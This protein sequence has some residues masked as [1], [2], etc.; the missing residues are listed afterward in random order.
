M[1]GWPVIYR[2]KDFSCR[3]AAHIN[4]P[5]GGMGMNG[6]IHDAVNLAEN[7]RVF[8]AVPRWKIWE[9][10]K[11]RDAVAIETVQA[12]ALRN[13]AILN[14]E[15]EAQRSAY[16]KEL[17]DIVAD[18]RKHKEYVMRSAMIT[19]LRELEKVE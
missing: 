10:M 4:N 14:A 17:Q 5:L 6:G 8:G 13:R 19:S 15:N 12:Q 1:K 3:D 18:E 9:D 16:Y 7:C 11:G 2:E